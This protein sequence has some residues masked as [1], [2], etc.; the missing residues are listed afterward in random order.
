MSIDDDLPQG[1]QNPAAN[2]YIPG[3]HSRPIIDPICIIMEKSN[4]KKQ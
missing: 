2:F 4:G 1:N 3:W